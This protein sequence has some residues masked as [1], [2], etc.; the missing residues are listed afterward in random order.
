MT[1]RRVDSIRIILK[2]VTYGTFPVNSEGELA[3]RM[4]RVRS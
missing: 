1:A 4:D 3:A 2:G